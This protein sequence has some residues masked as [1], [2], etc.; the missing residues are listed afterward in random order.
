ME[1]KTVKCIKCQKDVPVQESVKTPKGVVCKSC[2]KKNRIKTALTATGILLVIIAGV[3]YYFQTSKNNAI[4]F[5]RIANIQDSINVSIQKHE[6]TFKLEKAVAQANPVIVG[7]AIDNI[8]SFKRVF[9]ENVENAK[10]NNSEGVIIPNISILFNFESFNLSTA[11]IE[12]LKEYARAY[13]QTNKEAIILVEGFTCNIGG[14]YVNNWISEQRAKSA[15]RV[16]IEAGIPENKI[17][18]K[19]YGKSRFN[20]FSYPSKSEYRCVVLSIK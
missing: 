20:E 12:L 8:E 9:A 17:E 18:V 13:L 14:K 6:E 16:L 7:Q 4:G 3:I 5:E 1:E 2:I 15:Q 10:E 19:W 11:S